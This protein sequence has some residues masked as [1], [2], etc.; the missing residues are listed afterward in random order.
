MKNF[1][2]IEHCKTRP[3]SW[4][5]I[6]S[7]EWDPEQW[8]QRYVMNIRDPENIQMKFGKKIGEKLASDPTFMPDVLRYPQFEKSLEAEVFGI[9]IIGFLDSFD[10]ETKAFFEY[11]TSSNTKKW[12][13]QSAYEHGQILM[14]MLLIWI[15]YGVTP[16]NI[17]SSLFY[18][19]VH[20]INGK[21]KLT[22]LPNQSFSVSHTTQE[23]LKFGSKIKNITIEM[24]RYA[25]AHA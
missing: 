17:K 10:P 4:S 12:K 18:I 25:Q 21:M 19:P 2:I 13:Q 6:S 3:L 22:T 23:V 20:E 24:E 1:N 5:A 14:Y 9:K 11:K 7:F 15:N 16:E 8:Y